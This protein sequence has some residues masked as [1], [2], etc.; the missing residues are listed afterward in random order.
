M[1]QATVAKVAFG[2]AKFSPIEAVE[3]LPGKKAFQIRFEDGASMVEPEESIRAANEISPT[4]RFQDVSVDE[5]LKQGFFVKYDTGEIAEVSWAFVRELPPKQVKESPEKGLVVPPTA[6]ISYSHDSSQHKRWVASL[7]DKLVNNG[8]D[9]I[10]DQWDSGPGDDLP[11]FME[12]AVAR[13]DRVLMVCTDPYVEKADDGKG[14]VGFETMIVTGE[15]VQNLGLNKFIPLIRQKPG[16]QRKPKFLSTRWHIDFSSEEEFEEKFEELLRALHNAPRHPKPKLGPNPFA[17]QQIE[18]TETVGEIIVETQP[19]VAPDD[20]PLAFYRLSLQLAQNGNRV[21]WRK[22]VQ[23]VLSDFPEALRNW[24]EN[25]DPPFPTKAEDIPAWAAGGL[26]SVDKLYAVALAGV[27]SQEEYFR[28]QVGLVEELLQ[29]SGWERSGVT[30]LTQ[31]PEFLVFIYQALVGA[32]ATQTQQTDV[33]ERMGKLE[34]RDWYDQREPQPLFAYTKLTG[35]PESLNHTVTIAWKFLMD[36]PDKW[37]WLLEIFGPIEFYRAA[38]CGYYEFLN[39]V[40]FLDAVQRDMDLSDSTR[41]WPTV[42]ICFSVVP[43]PVRRRSVRMLEDNRAGV[44]K[45]WEQVGSIAVKAEKWTH[46]RSI[47]LQWIHEVY[48]GAF[49][50]PTIPHEGFVKS[51]QN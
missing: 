45:L 21:Q 30:T 4:A 39:I 32:L 9:V 46:W 51:L 48:R 1:S 28:N 49:F 41:V 16:S 17:Q 7:A 6:F 40:E 8:V 24:R 14:G 37:P 33:A 34:V 10:F 19:A 50:R 43:E 15:L 2:T 11:R 44:Q 42:P 35:W 22:L 29:P 13:A 31:Y 36:L 25:P 47:M 38:I 26:K 3:Y 23:R 18:T 20:S 5:D 12:R 27:D